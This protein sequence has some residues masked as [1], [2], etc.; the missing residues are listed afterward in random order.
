[1]G[2][3]D[4]FT[5]DDKEK[6]DEGLEKTRNSFFD[7]VD[8]MVRG[9]N[10]VDAETLDDLEELLVTSDVGVDTTLTIIDRI[11]ERVSEDAYVS[12]E[13]LNAM[14][15]E[16]IAALMKEA[17]PDRPADFEAPLPAKPYV[18]M[19]VGVNGTGKTTT[20]G[21][22]AYRYRRAGRSVLL[23]AADTYRAAAI[24]QLEIWADRAEVPLIKQKQGSDPAAVAST[25]SNRASAGTPTW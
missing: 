3:L 20:I 10:T 4:R 22:L 13:E 5:S 14:I 7:K 16:E 11:E 2:W 25:P 19:V 6:L 12:S 24:E 21:K 1:M 9:K 18:V 15:Q 17:H 8:K 23:G